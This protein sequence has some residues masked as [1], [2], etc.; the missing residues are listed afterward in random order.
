MENGW[1]SVIIGQWIRVFQD[2]TAARWSREDGHRVRQPPSVAE[3]VS[4]LSTVLQC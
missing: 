1:T 3:P 4:A 2:P